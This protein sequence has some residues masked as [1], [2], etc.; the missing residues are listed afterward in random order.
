MVDKTRYYDLEML[1]QAKQKAQSVAEKE[2]FQKIMN[3]IFSEAHLAQGEREYL[4]RAVQHGDSR[5]VAY[6][7][8]KIKR[9]VRE[10]HGRDTS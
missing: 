10:A 8:E 4:V 9:I 3:K 2:H 7:S 6:Y 5:A 1:Y